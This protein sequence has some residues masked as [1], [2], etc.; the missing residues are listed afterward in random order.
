MWETGGGGGWG[1]K[2]LGVSS[3]RGHSV[4]VGTFGVNTPPDL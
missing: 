3:G 2:P 4:L 1:G